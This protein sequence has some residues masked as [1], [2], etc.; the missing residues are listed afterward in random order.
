MLERD[1]FILLG[2]GG[3]FIIL[4]LIAIFWGRSQEKSY[5]NNLA[6]RPGDAREFIE[7]PPRLQPEALRVG[8]WMGLAIGI[9]LF[10][11]GGIFWLLL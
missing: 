2:V 1:C 3:F 9:V 5:Y 11:T 8:G 4:G 6:T 7:H 10:I